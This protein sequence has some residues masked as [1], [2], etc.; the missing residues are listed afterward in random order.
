MFKILGF[1]L[2]SCGNEND[3]AKTVSNILIIIGIVRLIAATY[4][5]SN[6]ITEKEKKL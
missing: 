2:G 5:Y 1:G 3:I 4:Y 6:A